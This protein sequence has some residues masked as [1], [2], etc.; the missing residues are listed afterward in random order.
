MIRPVEARRSV[1]TILKNYN[2]I[3][4][5]ALLAVGFLAFVDIAA[6]ATDTTGAEIYGVAIKGYDPVAYFTENRAVKGKSEFAYNWNEAR[7]YFS[8]AENR[9][10]FAANPKKYTPYHGGFCAVSLLAGKVAAEN[11][12]EWKIING[13]LYLGL[14]KPE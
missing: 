3:I 7:W 12:E 11:P 2:R 10:L 4:L 6:I 5:S 8:K 13:K 9:D 14:E 1:M